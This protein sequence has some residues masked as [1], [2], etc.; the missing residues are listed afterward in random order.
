MDVPVDATREEVV[1][2]FRKACA[3]SDEIVR[4]CPDL[5][6]MSAIANPGEEQQDPLPRDRGA[7]DQGDRPA[8]RSRR[9]LRERIDDATDL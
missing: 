3:R 9:H 2:A 8:R 6:T 4:A 5:S 7:P 1:A